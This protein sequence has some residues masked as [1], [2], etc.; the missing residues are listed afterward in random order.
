MRHEDNLPRIDLIEAHKKERKAENFPSAPLF[1]LFTVLQ[2]SEFFSMT[3]QTIY[4]HIESKDLQRP[5][6][7]FNGK[8]M[9]VVLT[10]EDDELIAFLD[11]PFEEG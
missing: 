10:E 8:V 4:N 11:K 7:E 2:F 3:R 1:K 6:V 9:I 5:V